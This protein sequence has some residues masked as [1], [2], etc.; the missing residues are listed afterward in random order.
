MSLPRGW[1]RSTLQECSQA[2]QYGLT[3]TSSR[4]GHGYLYVR[5]TDIQDGQI[6]W[7]NVPFADER[8]AKV[9]AYELAAGDILFARTGGTVGKSFLVDALKSPAVFASYLIRLRCNQAIILPQFAALFLQSPDY[10]RQIF[11]GATGTGQ[12]NFNGTK[13]ANLSLPLPPLT[14]QRRI[15]AKLDALLA[16]LARARAELDRIPTLAENLRLGGLRAIFHFRG[17]AN[18]LPTGWSFKRVDEIGDVQLG[19]QR[20][21]KDHDGPHMRPYVRAANVTWTGWDL[22]DVKEM[23]FS[24]AEFETFRLVR[25]DVV[26][27]EGSGSAKEVGKPVVWNDEIENAC[28]QNTLV[29]I[30][31]HGYSSNLLR[32][33]LLYVARSGQFI[34]STQ[35]V[36][37]IHIG[38]A[39]LARTIIPV[40][41]Q[42]QQESLLKIVDD[43]FARADRLEAEAA[44]ARAL[45]DRLEAAILTKAFKGELVPQDPNDEPA[46]VLLERIKVDRAQELQSQ[47]NRGRKAIAPRIPREKK[48]AMTKSR[49]DDEVKNKPYLADMIRKVGGAST[50]EALFKLADLSL[51]DFYKQLAWEVDHGHIFDDA[52]QELKAA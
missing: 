51:T 44:R 36:N 39:G 33:C 28:F 32:Y 26:L 18:E 40:P 11:E 41:P 48:T 43:T 27:N 25:G 34:S 19:R 52:N 38:K 14:E 3:C 20:S 30:R 47:P 21:P 17:D 49:Q 4:N 22:S 9:S 10:W 29:R 24:P 6:K 12:P 23:N 42:D 2:I 37:I 15:V 1:V 31:P 5:I 45:L 50:V 8:G 46:S 13:L 7:E 35:G 16:R